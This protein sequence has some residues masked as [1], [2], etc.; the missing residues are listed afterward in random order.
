VAES[1]FNLKKILRALTLFA[2]KT[3]GLIMALLTDFCAKAKKS[4]HHTNQINGLLVAWLEKQSYS[5]LT[6]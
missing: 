6:S 2:P 5:G 1:G 4:N 3:Y